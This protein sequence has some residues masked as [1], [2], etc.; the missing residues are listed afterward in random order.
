MYYFIIL[1]WLKTKKKLIYF[2]FIYRNFVKFIYKNLS[3]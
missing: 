1:F 3:K 2:N